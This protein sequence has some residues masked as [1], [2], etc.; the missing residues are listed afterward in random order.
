ML[1]CEKE[2]GYLLSHIGFTAKRYRGLSCCHER[3]PPTADPPPSPGDA[4]PVSP[5]LTHPPLT[6][7]SRDD[8]GR[9]HT[10][11]SVS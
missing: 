11:A 3:P 2:E 7:T 10:C 4:G 5:Q 1:I 9:G 8:R 6:A